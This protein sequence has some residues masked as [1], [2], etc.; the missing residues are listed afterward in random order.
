MSEFKDRLW[1]ELV[2]E[3]GADLARLG[4]PAAK[5]SRRARP[6]VLAGTTLALAALG[7]ALT[8]ALS[9]AGTPPAFAVTRNHDGTVTVTIRTWSAIGRANG[10]LSQL[11][12]RAEAVPVGDSCGLPQSRAMPLAL[13]LARATVPTMSLILNP[14]RIPLGRVAVLPAYRVGGAVR[15]TRADTVP[16]SSIPRCLWIPAAVPLVHAPAQ[17]KV[18]G[19]MSQI[20]VPALMPAAL[21]AATAQA[22]AGATARARAAAKLVAKNARNVLLRVLPVHVCYWAVPVLRPAVAGTAARPA[23]AAAAGN[24]PAAPRS[25]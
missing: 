14:R 21:A 2:R 12:I 3:H 6:R 20:K 22:R 8:L 25:R 16:G 10:K 17:C 1:R 23:L 19:R 18:S 9:A 5:S 4:R 13:R 7:T 11:G 15:L 24:K